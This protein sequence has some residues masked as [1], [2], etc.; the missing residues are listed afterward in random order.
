MYRHNSLLVFVGL[1]RL[2]APKNH[3]LWVEFMT[4]F[5]EG[6]LRGVH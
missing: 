3:S 4:V 1:D 2:L 5:K 6:N